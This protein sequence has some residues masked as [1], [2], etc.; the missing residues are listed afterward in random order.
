[1]TA[2]LLAGV[3]PHAGG[4]KYCSTLLERALLPPVDSILRMK[5]DHGC[6]LQPQSLIGRSLEGGRRACCFDTQ[7]TWGRKQIETDRVGQLRQ[8][9]AVDI[10]RKQ[11]IAPRHR[12]VE[13][14]L[15]A[16]PR[17]S[18][19]Q[20]LDGVVRDLHEQHRPGAV[21]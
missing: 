12:P 20:L 13:E 2:P 9:S 10:D 3:Y 14:E 1:M 4:E 19:G 5:R 11:L 7:P 18:D 17:P 15:L 16:I 21:H 8:A 6:A